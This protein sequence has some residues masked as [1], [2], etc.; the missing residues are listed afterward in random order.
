MTADTKPLPA[1]GQADTQPLPAADE[2]GAWIEEVTEDWRDQNASRPSPA[3]PA[4]GAGVRGR[5]RHVHGAGDPVR[6]EARQE[7]ARAVDLSAAV[8]AGRALAVSIVLVLIAFAWAAKHV[9]GARALADGHGGTVALVYA[10]TFGLLA[11]QL[12]LC[13]L[14][15]P[16]A[17]T[18]PDRARLGRL[19]VTLVV[20]VFNEDPAILARALQSML[21]QTRR[22]GRIAVVDDGSDK[23]EYSAVRDGFQMAAAVLGVRTIWV[24]TP[25]NR[26]KRHAHAV[27]MRSDPDADVFIT[28]DSDSILDAHAI[29]NLLVPFADP[30]VQSVAG[31]VLAANNRSSLLARVTDLLY[32]STQLTVRASLSVL[33]CVLVNSGCLAAYRS[34]VVRDALPAYTGETFLGRGVEFSDDSMLTLH[35]LLRG[36][37]VQATGAVA[38]AAMPERMSHH[39]RQYLRWMRGSFIRSWWRFRYLPMRGYAYWWHLA[40]WIMAV[41]TLGVFGDL[42]AV[43]PVEHRFSWTFLLVPVLL[44]YA[45]NLRYL[46]IRRNDERFASRLL[47]WLLAPLAVVWS[48]TVLRAWRWYGALTCWRTGWGTRQDGPEITLEES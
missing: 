20:P 36:R 31:L 24:K 29:E 9:T 14:D 3:R 18:P 6:V 45:L 7:P 21:D 44:G 34:G 10:A 26:G 27:A 47:T 46:T 25:A 2:I 12:I 32:V 16:R 41:T 33:G 8:S 4:Q 35:A 23:A 13:A 48:Y 30:R 11:W 39:R 22:P 40:T 5:S 43:D 15:R 42:Y 19:G 17:V 28:V 1:L 38:F 37:T